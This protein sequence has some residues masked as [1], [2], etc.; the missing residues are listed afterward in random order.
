MATTRRNKRRSTSSISPPKPRQTVCLETTDSTLYR[1][2]AAFLNWAS[3]AR[4]PQAQA[5]LLANQFI[6]QNRGILHQLGVAIEIAYDGSTVDL[7]FRT[8]TRVGAIPL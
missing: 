3:T 7:V 1:R 8:G 2:P 4:D 6:Q 5:A